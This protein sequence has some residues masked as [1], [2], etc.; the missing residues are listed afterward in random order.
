MLQVECTTLDSGIMLN[1]PLSELVLLDDDVVL[2][3]S[4]LGV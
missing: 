4:E 1:G 3:V 2:V